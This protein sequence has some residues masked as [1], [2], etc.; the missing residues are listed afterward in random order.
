[1]DHL[2]NYNAALGWKEEEQENEEIWL[3]YDVFQV[4]IREVP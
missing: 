3:V 4:Q 1:M 2:T